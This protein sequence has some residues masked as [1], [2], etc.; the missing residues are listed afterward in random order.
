MM[1]YC[2]AKLEKLKRDIQRKSRNG[3]F[4]IARRKLNESEVTKIGRILGDVKYK[5]GIS[6]DSLAVK[7]MINGEDVSSLL[8]K[9]DD[10]D[11]HIKSFINFVSIK[12]DKM[13]VQ[14][15]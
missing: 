13:D 10:D 5:C 12:V 11:K 7:G 9:D 3:E 15:L 1:V 14:N 8:L 2:S 6:L 4:C